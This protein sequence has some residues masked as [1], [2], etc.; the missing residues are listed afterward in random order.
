MK[1]HTGT[2]VV[3][4]EQETFDRAVLDFSKNTITNLDELFLILP[5]FYAEFVEHFNNDILDFIEA[6]QSDYT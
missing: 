3:E 5:N 4:M 2:K 1:I 6:N